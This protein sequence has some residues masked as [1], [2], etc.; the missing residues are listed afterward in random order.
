[1]T[2]NI[3]KTPSQR[4]VHTSMYCDTTY[5]VTAAAT[6]ARDNTDDRGR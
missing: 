3:D 1:M 4:H 2:I 6:A 5:E